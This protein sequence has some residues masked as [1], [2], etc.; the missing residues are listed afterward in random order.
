IYIYEVKSSAYASDCIIEALGQILLYT[1][2]DDDRRPK[3]LIVVGQH[4]PTDAEAGF[5]NYVKEKLN[6]DFSYENIDVE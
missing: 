1:H 5:V 6:L 4:K 2:R 3:K